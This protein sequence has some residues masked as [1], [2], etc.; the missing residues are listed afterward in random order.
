MIF[1]QMDQSKHTDPA[2]ETVRVKQGSSADY[3]DALTRAWG[4]HTWQPRWLPGPL[5][6]AVRRLALQRLRRG[7]LIECRLDSGQRF[8][9]D[10]SEV[11]QC[12]IGTRGEWEG[13]IY[14]AVRPLV[15][16]G[17]IVLDIGAHV[18]YSTVLFADWVG[19][20]G[21][22]YSFEPYAPHVERILSNLQMNELVDRVE[23]ISA[24]VSDVEG[25]ADFYTA[26]GLNSGVG[27][28][29]RPRRSA[30][31]MTV[32]T[33]RLDDWIRQH[34]I[35]NV[36]LCKLDIEGA[37]GAAL[38]GMSDTLEAHVVKTFLIEL[39]PAELLTM[40]QSVEGVLSYIAEAGYDI[41]YW[42]P[43][44]GFVRQPPPNGFAYV[45]AATR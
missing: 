9:V 6:G 21:K 41:S 25:S 18:G 45:L 31:S 13:D 1:Q 17:D 42:H 37:E 30:T 40:G 3:R 8:L 10:P 11:I 33:I 32:S 7:G 29:L 24:A 14:Q 5:T 35:I 26:V 44:G 12:H 19:P 36:A 20:A 27:S 15:H 43:E 28:L 38:K 23:I 16:D 34:A 2:A 39:H 22:V 4:W